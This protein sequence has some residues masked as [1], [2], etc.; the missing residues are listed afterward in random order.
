[1]QNPAAGPTLTSASPPHLFPP[2]VS[3]RS[4]SV[5][6]PAS[7]RRHAVTPRAHRR[8][9]ALSHF[10]QPARVPLPRSVRGVK[11]VAILIAV[12]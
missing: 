6:R 10:A 3:V 12:L 7:A 5:Q 1:M 11:L 9:A 8:D 4:V 2:P